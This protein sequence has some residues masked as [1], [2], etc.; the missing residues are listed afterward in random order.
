MIAARLR[1]NPHYL[2]TGNGDPENL[3]VVAPVHPLPPELRGL[4][5]IELG[6]FWNEAKP[7]LE[8]IASYRKQKKQA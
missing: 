7:I 4:D 5:E 6:F 8:K 3:T 2:R 1:L